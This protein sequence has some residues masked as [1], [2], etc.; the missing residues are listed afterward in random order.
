MSPAAAF[1]LGLAVA[2]L[3]GVILGL[4]IGW[5]LWRREKPSKN[6]T[7]MRSAT[8]DS[9]VGEPDNVIVFRRDY[10]RPAA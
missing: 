2:W 7:Y 1:A 8:A 9:S 5:M 6:W 3:I 10:G 4:R